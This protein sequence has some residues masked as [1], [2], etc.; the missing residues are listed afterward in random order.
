[1]HFRRGALPDQ[2]SSDHDRR[3]RARPGERSVNWRLSS[4][5]RNS[6]APSR[7]CA[8]LPHTRSP[9]P[10]SLS[11][12]AGPRSENGLSTL[13]EG[14]YPTSSRR[15]NPRE[16]LQREALRPGSSPHCNWVCSDGRLPPPGAGRPN[17]TPNDRT[18]PDGLAAERLSDKIKSCQRSPSSPL[19]SEAFS[20]PTRA[21]GRPPLVS[22]TAT[23][24]SSLRGASLTRTSMPS[25]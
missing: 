8:R 19:I 7:S 1:M 12:M 23:M 14:E 6:V 11:T 9:A 5:R 3:S 13:M 24:I 15:R 20:P 17:L 2:R 18:P 25:K 10:P 22:T 21:S 4:L 16:N